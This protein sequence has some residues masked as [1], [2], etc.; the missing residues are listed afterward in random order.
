M[1]I[2]RIT[3]ALLVA[4][5]IACASAPRQAQ[6]S[7]DVARGLAE[8]SPEPRRGGITIPLSSPKEAASPAVAPRELKEKLLEMTRA[9]VAPDVLLAYV[10]GTA[11]LAQD[12]GRGHHRLDEGRD[13]RR[14][15]RS[16]RLTLAG[17]NSGG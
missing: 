16:R 6:P 14:R 7:V 10:K 9:G 1:R 15:D 2:K 12:D 11:S 5:G 13:P 3:F 4:F 17:A 8:M